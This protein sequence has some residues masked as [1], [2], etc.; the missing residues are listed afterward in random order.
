M[1]ME[2]FIVNMI[3]A[4][5]SRI[6]TKSLKTTGI[7]YPESNPAQRKGPRPE[8]NGKEELEGCYAFITA[9]LIT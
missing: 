4:A 8:P 3:Q 1:L 6:A 2:S 5:Y 9:T 7:A